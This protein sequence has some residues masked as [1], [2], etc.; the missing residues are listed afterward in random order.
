[1]DI[2][3]KIWDADILE[4]NGVKSYRKD[5]QDSGELN[6]VLDKTKG[7]VIVDEEVSGKNAKVITEVV[8]PPSKIATY[9]L[10][11]KLF[12]NYILD[13]GE[14]DQISSFERQEE[15]EFIEAILSTKPIQIAK[16]A[17]GRNRGRA[18]TDIEFALAIEEAFFFQ[19]KAGSKNA[20]GFEHVF[21][22]E[23]KDT[24]EKPDEIAVQLG[25]YHFWYK[26]FLDDGG[27]N[28]TM[29]FPDRISYG[30]SEYRG[31]NASQGIL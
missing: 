6:G 30:K 2:Y 16:E 22:G 14:R 15:R 7:Y 13:P 25:G 17:V 24:G 12:N 23:Q 3:Q 1:M 19:G 9:N 5:Q 18:L 20:S 4:G 31:P 28:S 29:E 27:K 8:I 10:C 21:V 26:Y 11:R